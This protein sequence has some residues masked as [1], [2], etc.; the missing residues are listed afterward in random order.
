MIRYGI[1]C[2]LGALIGALAVW[3]WAHDDAD[4]VLRDWEAAAVAQQ[5]AE[6]KRTDAITRRMTDGHTADLSELRRRLVA[7]W[8]PAIPTAAGL[9]A[10]NLHDPA[11]RTD[12]GTADDVPDPAGL[13]AC[14]AERARLIG[15]G[16]ET[17]LQLLFLQ[18]WVRQASESIPDL[19]RAGRD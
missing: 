11:G 7:G 1:G 13:A 9:P 8:R 19:V 4:Q 6:R 17:T 16:A 3:Q 18:E 2:L 5:A 15:D 14:Q 10:G 12:G